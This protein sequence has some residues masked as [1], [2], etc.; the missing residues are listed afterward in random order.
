MDQAIDKPYS[1]LWSINSGIVMVVT[2]LHGDWQS[3]KLYRDRFI[4]LHGEGTADFLV[5]TGDLIHPQTADAP[6]HSLEI[7]LDVMSLKQSFGDSVI[8]LCGNHELPH[9]YHFALSKGDREYTPA[10][11]SA[12]NKSDRRAEILN[13]FSTLPF[14]LRTKSGVSIT[15]AGAM[16]NVPKFEDAK[17]LFEWDHQSHLAQAKAKISKMEAESLR[18]GYANLSGESSYENMAKHY[19]AVTGPNDPRYDNLLIGLFAISSLKFQ[20]LKGALFTKCEKEYGEPEYLKDLENTLQHLSH[21]YQ[22]QKFLVAGHMTIPSGYQFVNDQH[23]RLASGCHA[24]SKESGMY[25]LFDSAK[26]I[27]KITELE[28]GLHNIWS[29]I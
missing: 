27:E 17:T 1:R 5:F 12:L 13:F 20:V 11:E 10:F 22:A 21:S 2:D 19:L 24:T 18:S 28:S 25:L 3:Y 7:V 16:P 8:Y 4:S 14:Y 29:H 6:D 26:K 23:L 9:I 15:H